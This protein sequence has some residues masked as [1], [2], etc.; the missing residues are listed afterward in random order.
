MQASCSTYS[1]CG[2]AWLALEANAGARGKILGKATVGLCPS[3]SLTP[4]TGFRLLAT[5]LPQMPEPAEL[6]LARK[7]PPG[8]GDQ[9]AYD[10]EKSERLD[11]AGRYPNAA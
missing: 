10:G 3:L 5:S 8:Q 11:D 4:E 2:L 1:P 7:I 9:H 6:S